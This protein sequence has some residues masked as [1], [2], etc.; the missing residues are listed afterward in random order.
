VHSTFSRAHTRTL[1]TGAMT[2]A[3]G[4]LAVAF[5][6][7]ASAHVTV[8]STDARQGGYGKVAVRVPNESE[9]AGTIKVSVSIPAGTPLSSVRIKPHVGWTAT[10]PKVALAKPFK[11]GDRTITETVTTITWTADKGVSIK[12][13]TFD[14]FEFSAGQLPTTVKSISFP[15]IQTYSDGKVVQW[16]E[17]V[18]KGAA[19]PEHPAPVLNLLPAEGS[20]K[21]PAAALTSPKASSNDS[22]ARGGAAVAA[23]VA[24]GGIG[25]ALRRK[26]SDA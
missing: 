23:L 17:P 22:L 12:P 10:A 11:Q 5:A 3:L 25:V 21:A 2:L 8:N 18:V 13:G 16:S 14:E 24:F 4:S 1:T 19:E 6:G 9:T 26:G 7:S 20:E 15:A